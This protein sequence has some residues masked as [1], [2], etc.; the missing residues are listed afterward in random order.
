MTA[1][2][3]FTILL[4]DDS[5]EILDTLSALLRPD[6]KVLAAR[7]GLV[8]L[9]IAS[10]LPQ[11]HLVLLDVMMPDVDGY[12]V[13]AR[14]K[15]NPL[16]RDIP[17]V[18]LTSLAD[19]ESE[20]QG[21]ELGA[22]DFISKPIKPNIL[23]ARV[24]IQLEARQARELLKRQNEQLKTDVVHYEAEQD[25]TQ[26]TAIRALAHLAET[27]DDATGQHVARVQNFVWLL[28]EL[29]CEHPRFKDVLT[30]E[31]IDLLVQS[32]PL[33]DIGKVGIPDN[34]L[35]KA[36]PLDEDEW[37]VMKTHAVL[38]SEAIEKAE[39]D[40]GRPTPFLI[41]AKEIARSHHEKWAGGGY[42]DGLVGEAIPVSARLVALAD[43]F[44]AL[45]S[46][47]TY[48]SPLPLEE[49]REIIAKGR[50][51]QFDPDVTDAFLLNF[52]E[53]VEIVEKYPH[54]G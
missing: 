16:T 39:R 6:Y 3:K 38:G 53:F 4:I 44:D 1:K 33:H 5:P 52:D 51:K 47:R 30:T 17:V 23:K 8:G 36:G 18:F 27:R 25:L 37:A 32:T 2:D 7:S 29:L 43:V 50:G 41:L 45:I 28:A 34:I 13:L 26:Y 21:L 54:I 40:I 14:M 24:R 10:R 22:S 9:D 15:E 48:K 49:A 35:R 19:P 42:P 20:E 11:P 46:R 12:A 31:Y